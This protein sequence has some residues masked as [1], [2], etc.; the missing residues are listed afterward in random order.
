MTTDHRRGRK[1]LLFHNLFPTFARLVALGRLLEFPFSYL[2]NESQQGLNGSVCLSTC[3][4]Y[5]SPLSPPHEWH[6]WWG[7]F[8][9][10]MHR[11]IGHIPGFESQL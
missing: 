1:G 3:L 4:Q 5:M 8:G 10:E 2:C 7:Q 11:L 6:W 9:L